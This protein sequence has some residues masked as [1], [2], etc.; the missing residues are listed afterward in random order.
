[1]RLFNRDKDTPIK[2]GGYEFI[3]PACGACYAKEGKNKFTV[4][5]PNCKAHWRVD[6]H[7]YVKTGTQV[8]VV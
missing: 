5:C 7:G 1:M 3:C 4:T 6:S 2:K 8:V